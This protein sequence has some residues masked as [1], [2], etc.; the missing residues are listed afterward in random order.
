M[1]A[2]I[3]INKV[4][5]IAEWHKNLMYLNIRLDAAPNTT[6]IEIEER[7]NSIKLPAITKGVD[8][9]NTVEFRLYTVLN[10]I[11]LTMSLKTPSP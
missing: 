10:R 8:A 9:V 11:I 6:P 5:V 2:R 3:S 7:A 1:N 4:S